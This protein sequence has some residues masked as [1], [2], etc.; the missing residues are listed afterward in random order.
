MAVVLHGQ[1]CPYNCPTLAYNLMYN[2]II[3][4]VYK[5]LKLNKSI[6]LSI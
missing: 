4:D 5:M 6:Y 1:L 3:V 2:I